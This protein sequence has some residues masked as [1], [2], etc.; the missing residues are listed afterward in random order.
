M[1]RKIWGLAGAAVLVAVTATGA[2]VGMS[3]AT[4]AT[5][6]AQEPPANTVPVERGELAAMVSL[7]GTLTYRARPDGSPYVV[8]NQ[9][10]G[11]YT[12]L[13]DAGEKFDC[14]D[15]LYRVD[16]QPV[17]L[18]CGTVPAYR[19]LDRGDEGR[20]VRQLNRNLRKL[21]YDAGPGDNGFSSRT[22]EALE[23][24]QADKGLE[25]TGELD[26]DEAVFLPGPA[27]I[28]KLTGELG[29]AA[30]PGARLALATSDSLGVQVELEAFQQGRVKK[31]DRARITIPGNRSVTGRVDRLG[32]VAQ[33]PEGQN[34]GAATIPAHVSLDDPRKA[35]GL[36]EAPVQVDVTTDGV[37]SA[38]SVPVTALL[39]RSG[40]GFAVEVVGAGGRRELVAVELGLFDTSAGR[41]EVEGDL[42]AGDRVVVPSL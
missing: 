14:G 21:G 15:V 25:G 33:A 18:L 23:E 22:E 29:G 39:G 6:A 2:V 35:R 31:G 42:D 19:D 34:A 36:D 41:V 7:D 5:R 30:R 10:P 37:E 13:P 12:K 8:I 24:L 38:L 28:A 3:D 16:D 4:H 32:K 9:A 1:K 26:L 27:R 40:G 20:D 11:I 17:L